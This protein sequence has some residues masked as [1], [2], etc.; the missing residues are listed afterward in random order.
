MATNYAILDVWTSTLNPPHPHPLPVIPNDIKCNLLKKIGKHIRLPS[1]SNNPPAIHK[2]KKTKVLNTH[3]Y[4]S[5]T[6]YRM[7]HKIVQES[8]T[9][10]RLYWEVG[11]DYY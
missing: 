8:V 9:S 7:C 4:M 3:Y 11:Y 5:P 2:K 1:S 10:S 6:I